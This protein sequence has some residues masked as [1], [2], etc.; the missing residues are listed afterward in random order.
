MLKGNKVKL[1]VHGLVLQVSGLS[2]ESRMTL[3]LDATTLRLDTDVIGE[4]KTTRQRK[5]SP[6]ESEK[7]MW[8]AEAAWRELPSG[9]VESAT[10]IGEDLYILDGD[11]AFFISGSPLR[12][13]G[14]PDRPAAAAL[15]AALVGT[16]L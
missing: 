2:G 16:K 4:R 6:Y 9:P 14:H 15:V 8:F 13:L 5:I 7:L 3:D 1:P 11:D 10:D 12:S